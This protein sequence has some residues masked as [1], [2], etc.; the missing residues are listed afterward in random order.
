MAAPAAD[1]SENTPHYRDRPRRSFPRKQKAALAVAHSVLVIL[2]R[3]LRDHQPYSDLGAD[4]FD[5]LHRTRLQHR[6]VHQLERLGY[7]VTLTPSAA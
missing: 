7:T 5:Q 3:L 4:Y 6:H 1:L 2:H